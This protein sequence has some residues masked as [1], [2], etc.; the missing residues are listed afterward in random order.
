MVRVFLSAERIIRSS[1]VTGLLS[2]IHSTL[3]VIP[4]AAEQVMLTVLLPAMR[5]DEELEI[6][7][8]DKASSR[9]QQ[10]RRQVIS[11]AFRIWTLITQ[12]EKKVQKKFTKAAFI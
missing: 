4:A 12:G 8:P 1:K 3:S 11:D 7:V 9:T 6:F 10:K 2:F 5:S